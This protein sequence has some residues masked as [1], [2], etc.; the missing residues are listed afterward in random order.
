MKATVEAPPHGGLGRDSTQIRIRLRSEERLVYERLRLEAWQAGNPDAETLSSWVRHQLR[1][2]THAPANRER[3]RIPTELYEAL[4][5]LAE[6]IGMEP[7]A[8]VETCI[9]AIIAM[10]DHP[11]RKPPALVGQCQEILSKGT[12]QEPLGKKP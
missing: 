3:C 7:E 1:P 6:K 9:D 4:S 8:F 5:Q 10:A 11:K 2:L 12:R